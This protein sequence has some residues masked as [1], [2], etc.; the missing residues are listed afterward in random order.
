[1]AGKYSDYHR[2]PLL[3][4]RLSFDSKMAVLF[5]N[6]E[7]VNRVWIQRPL[8]ELASCPVPAVLEQLCMLFVD[9]DEYGNDCLSTKDFEEIYNTVYDQTSD[10]LHTLAPGAFTDAVLQEIGLTQFSM[11]QRHEILRFR[12]SWLFSY[13][14]DDLNMKETYERKF[15]VPYERIEMFAHIF[16]VFSFVPE[17]QQKAKVYLYLLNKVFSDCV[18]VLQI[19]RA[20]YQEQN[21][22]YSGNSIDNYAY[23]V[24]P[25]YTYAL[26]EWKGILYMPLPHLL[27]RNVT[28]SFIYRLTKGN[29]DLREKMGKHLYEDYLYYL[30]NSSGAYKAVYTEC[31]YNKGKNRVS[32]PDTMAQVDEDIVLFESKSTV[33]SAAIRL[34][35]EES[36]SKQIE[37]LAEHIAQLYDRMQEFDLYNPFGCAV[38]K[39]KLWGIVVVQEYPCTNRKMMYER[40][41]DRHGIAYDSPEYKWM[42]THIHVFDIYEVESIHLY[43]GSVMETLRQKLSAERCFDYNTVKVKEPKPIQDLLEYEERQNQWVQTICDELRRAGLMSD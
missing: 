7:Y 36:I 14:S 2:L 12:Y 35:S 16:D 34:L 42:I 28:T 23:C 25:S 43:G 38:Q 13:C 37:R 29:N 1:M 27:T 11:Q 24:R 3:F 22:E 18:K 39:D 5:A 31:D 41:A 20:D 9:G 17:S 21:A 40:A 30:V 15:G 33:P 4:K 32:S 26:I 19:S 8:K 6:S 10:Y